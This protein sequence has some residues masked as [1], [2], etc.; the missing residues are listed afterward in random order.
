MF[1]VVLNHRGP[2]AL[3]ILAILGVTLWL[4][5]RQKS[6]RS[7]S[8]ALPLGANP[9]GRLGAWI[10][11][12]VSALTTLVVWNYAR[13]EVDSGSQA[14]FQRQTAQL[15][16]A[17]LSRMQGV[18][19]LLRTTSDFCATRAF[20]RQKMW[21]SYVEAADL[22]RRYPGLADLGLA[23]Y[24]LSEQRE[25]FLRQMRADGAPDFKISPSGW[26]DDYIVVRLAEPESQ[27]ARLVGYDLG[28]DPA[29]RSLAERARDTGF[30]SLSGRTRLPD[31][32]ARA[33][34]LYLLP[35][36]NTPQTP[37]SP[38]DRR[39][40]I[41]GWV[42]A[43][44]QTEDLL[45]GLLDASSALAVQVYDGMEAR[46][47]ALLCEHS[48]PSDTEQ[49]P[50]LSLTHSIAVGGRNWTLHFAAGSG[51]SAS[52][53]AAKPW[54][55]LVVGSMSSLLGFG[56]LYALASAQSR[57]RVL[58]EQMAAPLRQR[59]RA[60]SASPGGI[61]IADA[62]QPDYPVIYVNAGFERLTG[63]AAIEV[64]GRSCRFLQGPDRDQKIRQEIRNAL[65]ERREYRT[66][67]R[68]F[69][70]DGTP[71][72]NELTLIPVRSDHG[73]VTQYVG[74]QKDV[75]ER[76]Q[77]ERRIAAQATI[78]RALAES[79]SMREAIAQILQTM[80]ES[81]GW[82][83]GALWGVDP[84]S[85]ALRC[86]DLWHAPTLDATEFESF[87][88]KT[89][90]PRDMGF[91]GFIW[92]KGEP[93]WVAD[94][95]QRAD[96]PQTPIVAKL[97]LHSAC[98]FPIVG[99]QGLLGVVEFYAPKI[100]ALDKNLLLMMV[101]TGSQIGQYVER[102][103]AEGALPSGETAEVRATEE[104]E[105]LAAEREAEWRQA[106]QKLEMEL[107][108]AQEQVDVL[109]Q[110]RDRLREELRTAA[111]S[112][113]NESR[114]DSPGNVIPEEGPKR[115]LILDE[116]ATVRA[117]LGKAL[118]IA[119]YVVL[120][121]GSADEA[122][123]IGAHHSEPIH[124]IITDVI[125]PD[126][127]S[128]ELTERLRAGHRELQILYISRHPRSAL[129][130]LE[131]LDASMQFLRIPFTPEA[132]LQKVREVLGGSAPDPSG[133]DDGSLV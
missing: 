118:Q 130:H 103:Q 45:K 25:S 38:A 33:S 30:A 39:D 111:Q 3:G 97:G 37:E 117:E 28:T 59:E 128:H 82:S 66:V 89:T 7:E 92:E 69:R 88:R 14:Q 56:W 1:D 102:M 91:P 109:R 110:E 18:E 98:G 116:D 120:E 71:F 124:L 114:A 8:E 61:V 22:P 123:H 60:L 57:A 6:P 125:L 90:L 43:R 11:L 104:G 62:T 53:D 5:F 41:R 94:L 31:D 40:T 42:W 13:G 106:Q 51:F 20:V 16:T 2:I 112:R 83:L 46:A 99:R 32:P 24:V 63:Y 72:L 48:A 75:T 21:R 115:V 74:F 17:L 101:S 15:Q 107:R 67:V 87:S 9:Q 129:D 27:N 127:K 133:P 4:I 126:M 26:R 70:K 19:D 34:L 49:S 122:L 79:D 105:R 78:T 100:W 50:A 81:Q 65:R 52:A 76:E 23:A 113:T 121:A 73:V 132:L 68:N 80:G 64:L 29:L 119:G 95:A 131:L 86:L 84:T 12:A 55:I 10:F 47:P 36:F 93:V 85:N 35:V 96:F 58:A 108:I 77:Y 54:W 44:Y